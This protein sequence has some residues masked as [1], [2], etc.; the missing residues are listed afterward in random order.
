M[1]TLSVVA[2][3]KEEAIGQQAMLQGWVRTRRDSKAG[4]SF[5]SS[6]MAVAWPIFRL[7]AMGCLRITK[8]KSKNSPPVAASR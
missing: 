1:D 8:P 3:R 4:F 2:A 5:W 7:F 6:T